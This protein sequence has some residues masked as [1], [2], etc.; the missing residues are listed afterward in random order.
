MNLCGQL[1]L[2][3]KLVPASFK[4]IFALSFHVCLF[5]FFFFFS[6]C[7]NFPDLAFGEAADESDHSAYLNANQGHPGP[8]LSSFPRSHQGGGGEGMSK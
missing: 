8:Q 7:V 2:T 1:G 4:N 5:A 3:P 6:P